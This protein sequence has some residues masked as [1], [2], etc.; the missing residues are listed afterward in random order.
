MESW[1][2]VEDQ[3]ME[4]AGEPKPV[5][6]S[7]EPV[8][9]PTAAE[10]TALMQQPSMVAVLQSLVAQATANVQ[11]QQM[12]AAHER[13]AHAEREAEEARQEAQCRGMALEDLRS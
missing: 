5:R 2:D 7:Q 4:E 6:E 8:R 12:Q 1:A 13:I 10:L 3:P 11:S 9:A